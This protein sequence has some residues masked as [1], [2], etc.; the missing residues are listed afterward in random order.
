MVNFVGS[1]ERQLHLKE[2]QGLL[3]WIKL[4]LLV[5]IQGV[6]HK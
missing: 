6:T 4:K 5:L 1:G 3:N 2:Q